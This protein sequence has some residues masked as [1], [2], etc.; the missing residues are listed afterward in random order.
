MTTRTPPTSRFGRLLLVDISF[1]LVGAAV[2]PWF[3]G[4]RSLP[5]Y[6]GTLAAIL[7]LCLAPL[8]LGGVRWSYLARAGLG[9]AIAAALVER[10]RGLPYD[11]GWL[12][13]P[14]VAEQAL[15]TCACIVAMF[16]RDERLP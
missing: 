3:D 13:A 2:L 16:V 6:S 14:L 11:L 4:G 15:V 7:A 12:F 1:L 5:G 10:A 9:F 8:C